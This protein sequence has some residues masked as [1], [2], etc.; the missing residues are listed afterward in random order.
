MAGRREG[1]LTLGHRESPAGFPSLGSPFCVR[2]LHDQAAFD[3]RPDGRGGES[4]PLAG[5]PSPARSDPFFC[6]NA[7]DDRIRY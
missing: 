1:I 6:C 4:D 3:G 5:N 2:T 7:D